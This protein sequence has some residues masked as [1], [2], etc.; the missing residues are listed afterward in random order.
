MPQIKAIEVYV[1]GNHCFGYQFFYQDDKK[2]ELHYGRHPHVSY[3]HVRPERVELQKGEYLTGM[4]HQCSHICHRLWFKT[5]MGRTI[6]F[7]GDGG[8]YAEF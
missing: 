8:N 7:G 6:S 3:E 2:T 4:G 5:S 1:D